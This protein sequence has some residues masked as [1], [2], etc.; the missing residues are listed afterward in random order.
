MA[1]RLWYTE[2][3][4]PFGSVFAAATQR[5]ICKISLGDVSR[6]EFVGQLRD[7]LGQE[8][9]ED[10]VHFKGLLDDLKRCFSGEAVELDYPTD[11]SGTTDFQ[12]RV[13]SE[14]KKIPRGET[15][16]YS[17]VAEAI[18]SPRAYRAVGQALGANPVP[19]IIPC[20]RVIGSDGSL[21]GFGSGLGTKEW[22]LRLEGAR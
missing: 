2:F 9:V 18:G 4:A 12:R 5:G 6:E 1:E 20:H 7:A 22:L 17:Q 13:W 21:T 3:R 14:T 10:R 8:P 19:M 11:L 16:T 15:R